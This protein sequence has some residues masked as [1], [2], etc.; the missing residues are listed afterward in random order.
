MRSIA[1]LF[2]AALVAVPLAAGEYTSEPSGSKLG[3]T[4]TQAGAEASG[5]FGTFSVKLGTAEDGTPIRLDV[6][7]DVASADTQDKE[8]NMALRGPELL[9][10]ARHPSAQ[11]SATDIVSAGADRYEAS[12]K[13]TIRGVTKGFR[14]PFTLKKTADGL[15]LA[16]ETT[17]RRLEFGV[18]QGDFKSTELVGDDVGLRYSVALRE[19]RLTP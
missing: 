16:G 11:F 14:L 13:L 17:I 3:F 4:F 5:T 12:G 8:R 6:T 19:A 7:V 9:D 1:L 18:G 2:I 10:A 15:Q